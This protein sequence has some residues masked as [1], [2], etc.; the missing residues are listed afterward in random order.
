M[1]FYFWITEKDSI[2]KKRNVTSKKERIESW[3]GKKERKL[4]E[5]ES[6]KVRKKREGSQT[7]V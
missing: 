1:W 5:K 3:E 7:M 2:R 6:K 4:G